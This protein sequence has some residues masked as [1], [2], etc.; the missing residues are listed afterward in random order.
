MGEFIE[1]I[2]IKSVSKFKQVSEA[3]NVYHPKVYISEDSPKDG[4]FTKPLGLK[5]FWP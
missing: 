1:I 4:R 5:I 3:K 2:Y